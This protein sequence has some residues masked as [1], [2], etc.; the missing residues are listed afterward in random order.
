MNKDRLRET[1]ERDEGCNLHIHVVDGKDHIGYGFNLEIEWAAELL[2]YLG[3]E[4]EDDIEQLTREQ[5]NFIL[6]HHIN[7]FSDKCR[8]IYGDTWDSLSDL[9]REILVNIC[10]NVGPAG[11]RKFRKMN[12]AIHEG[13]WEEAASQMVDSKA[14][15]QTGERYSRLAKTFEFDDEKHLEL[16]QEYDDTKTFQVKSES[17]LQ[18]YTDAELL[19]ELKRRLDFRKG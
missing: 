3:V 15:R 6:N 13:D 11:L 12:A 17:S 2:D 16:A 18:S 19:A 1:L 5:A 7:A 8:A 4:D 9:R 10:F 14:A